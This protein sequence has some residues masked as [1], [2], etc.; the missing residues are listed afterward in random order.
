MQPITV[1]P[2]IYT[3]E[4]EH[5]CYYVGITHNINMRYAQHLSGDGAG[6]TTLHKPLRILEVFSQDA[7]L[8][9]EN[10]ITRQYMEKYGEANVRGGSYCKVSRPNPKYLMA[11]DDVKE[12]C[13]KVGVTFHS[14]VIEKDAS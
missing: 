6:W 2:M 1:Y 14:S 5:G 9:R 13:N 7:T 8:R 11:D 3:L 12:M 10:E 4:L